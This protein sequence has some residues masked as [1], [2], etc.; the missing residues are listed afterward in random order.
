[1]QC[2]IAFKGGNRENQHYSQILN[3]GLGLETIMRTFDHSK[4]PGVLAPSG[5][6][7]LVV[8]SLLVCCEVEVDLTFDLL[9][10][11]HYFRYATTKI[12]K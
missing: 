3:P 8:D 1:M 10:V 5:D 11:G 7:V 2:G 9:L 12:V 4:L 6:V